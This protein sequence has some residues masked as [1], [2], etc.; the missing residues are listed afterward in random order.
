MWA[1]PS[2]WVH[3]VPVRGVRVEALHSSTTRGLTPWSKGEGAVP[4]QKGERGYLVKGVENVLQLGLEEA[5]LVKPHLHQPLPVD[6]AARLRPTRIDSESHPHWQGHPPTPAPSSPPLHRCGSS[7][8]VTPPPAPGR[9][10]VRGNRDTSNP[11]VEVSRFSLSTSTGTP[12]PVLL[13]PNRDNSTG[14]PSGPTVTPPTHP[15]KV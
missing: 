10:A 12:P 6:G 13:K 5:V 7:Q 14:A 2:T 1:R 9:R 15:R 4:G 3:R 11:P 8:T